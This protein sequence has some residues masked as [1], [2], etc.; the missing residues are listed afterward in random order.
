MKQ[1]NVAFAVN[2]QG[3]NKHETPGICHLSGL[4][5]HMGGNFTFYENLKQK[6]TRSILASHNFIL[7]YELGKYKIFYFFTQYSVKLG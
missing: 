3:T 4:A 5:I 6:N 7:Y 2:V 1:F